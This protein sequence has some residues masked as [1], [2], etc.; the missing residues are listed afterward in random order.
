MPRAKSRAR[1]DAASPEDGSRQAVRTAQSAD[2]KG[3][4]RAECTGTPHAGNGEM[5]RLLR[6]IE[7]KDPAYGRCP[8]RGVFRGRTAMIAQAVA[9]QLA[10]MT[11]GNVLDRHKLAK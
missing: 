2:A 10:G 9:P 7:A 1:N 4:A 3:A 6:D 11:P 8:S 5:W